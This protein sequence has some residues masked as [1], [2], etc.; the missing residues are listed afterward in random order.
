MTQKFYFDKIYNYFIGFPTLWFSLHVQYK[1]LDR[2]ILEIS[3]W[4]SAFIIRC[5][6]FFRLSGNL[7]HY[8]ILIIGVITILLSYLSNIDFEDLK[9]YYANTSRGKRLRYLRD[10]KGRII[11]RQGRLIE[12]GMERIFLNR[13]EKWKARRYMKAMDKLI[14]HQQKGM[15]RAMCDAR[16][17]QQIRD[18]VIPLLEQ[19]F[20]RQDDEA[21]RTTMW[22]IACCFFMFKA[23]ILSFE[24]QC[25]IY[26]K[27]YLPRDRDGDEKPTLDAFYA[28]IDERMILREQRKIARA[29]HRAMHKI[30][31]DNPGDLF[32][33]R[34]YN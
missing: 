12:G 31:K 26:D 17:Y 23:F 27:K 1:I 34:H 15:S 5:I 3:A 19:E 7:T 14:S 25:E 29:R 9:L 32:R 10:S 30:L 16:R 24:I 6:S 13:Y 28:E 20:K 4:S 2:G 22:I 21:W 11:D 33:L 18:V 8:I